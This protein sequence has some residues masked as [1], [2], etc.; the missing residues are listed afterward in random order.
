MAVHHVC[1]EHVTDSGVNACHHGPLD[2]DEQ[3]STEW[4][5]QGSDAH[6]AVQDVVLS[7]R[8]LGLSRYVASFRYDDYADSFI[9]DLTK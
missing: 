1:G 4:L 7:P 6:K 8:T 2:D 3:R 9:T 5:K